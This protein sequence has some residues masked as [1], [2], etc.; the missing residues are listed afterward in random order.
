MDLRALVTGRKG[1]EEREAFLSGDSLVI[2]CRGCA[3]APDPGSRECLACMVGSM[4]RIGGAERVVLR[5]GRD[6][7]ISGRASRAVKDVASLRRWSTPADRP[8]G[9]CR[10]CPVSRAAIVGR[11][12]ERFPDAMT[13]GLAEEVASHTPDRDGCRECAAATIRALEQID[14][15]MGSI[16]RRIVESG[17]EARRCPSRGRSASSA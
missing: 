16:R 11:V 8:R 2:D 1:G 6:V 10:R 12:W 14:A 4:C 5:T 15:G 9:L 7:E 13:D 17:G 3:L